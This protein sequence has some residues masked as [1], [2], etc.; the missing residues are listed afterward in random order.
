METQEG[1]EDQRT[2]AEM[3]ADMH[4][5]RYM[6]EKYR[7]YP[8]PGLARYILLARQVLEAAAKEKAFREFVSNDKP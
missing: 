1:N 2:A 5:L 7:N 3:V 4:R 8:I 6:Q